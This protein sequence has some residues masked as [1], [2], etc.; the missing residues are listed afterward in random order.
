[1]LKTVDLD[2]LHTG[3]IIVHTQRVFILLSAITTRKML[4]YYVCSYPDYDYTLNAKLVDDYIVRFYKNAFLKPLD[5]ARFIEVLLDKK[6]SMISNIQEVPLSELKLWYTKS[7]LSD[8]TLP[9]LKDISY[10]F[11]EKKQLGYVTKDDTLD[12][13][14]VY[15]TKK[16]GKYYIALGKRKKQL[17]GDYVFMVID[18]KIFNALKENRRNYVRQLLKEDRNQ[19]K[20]FRHCFSQ[21]FELYPTELVIENCAKLFKYYIY[22]DVL[23]NEN[24]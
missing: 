5:R 22:W 12:F 1:M 11:E 9:D 18:K 16:K 3:S 24:I 4:V 20:Y 23:E 19:D 21:N 15:T 10:K 2:E 17:G 8:A 14:R 6:V 7:K 13:G